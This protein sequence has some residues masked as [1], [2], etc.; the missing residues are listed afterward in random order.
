VAATP[1]Y[2][3]CAAWAATRGVPLREVL[4]AAQAAGR[5]LVESQRRPHTAS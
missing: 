2:D 3:D 1:E 5:A 4:D